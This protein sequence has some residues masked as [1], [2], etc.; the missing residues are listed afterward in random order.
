MGQQTWNN[1]LGY[2]RRNLG[3]NLNLLEMSDDEIIEGIKDDVLPYFS[4]YVPCKKF[5]PIYP[6]HR[7]SHTPGYNQWRY[8]IPVQE[9]ERIIDVFDAYFS[10][11]TAG[12]DDPYAGT[13]YEGGGQ[14]AG[15]SLAAGGSFGFGGG[16]A[17]ERF[18]GEGLIDTAIANAY[19]DISRYMMARNTWQFFP[20]NIIEFDKELG[21]GVVVYNT[22]HTDLKTIPADY[23]DTT[24]KKLILGNVQKWVAALRSKYESLNTPFGEVRLNYSKLE[25]DGQTNIDAAQALLDASP[26]DHFLYVEV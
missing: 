5:I 25:Q 19:G 17:D 10:S 26:L 4:Q 15:E 3:S 22:D 24:L 23:Y 18:V 13:K 8:V 21:A 12:W 20:P 14:H 2:L 6:Y 11:G 9:G 16:S 1:V 7:V